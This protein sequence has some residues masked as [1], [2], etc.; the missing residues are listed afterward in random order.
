MKDSKMINE[1]STGD[2]IVTY[3]HGFEECVLHDVKPFGDRFLLSVSNKGNIY[4]A[5]MPRLLRP[6][7]CYLVTDKNSSEVN[8]IKLKF[9]CAEK[10]RLE[11]L[12]MLRKLE[13]VSS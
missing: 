9:K 2:T 4:S 5:K 3:E 12:E 7:S 8:E 10:L 6:E 1:I 11:A 13:P